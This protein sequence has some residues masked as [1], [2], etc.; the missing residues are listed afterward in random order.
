M[1]F[2][3]QPAIVIIVALILSSCVSIGKFPTA[4]PMDDNQTTRVKNTV[5]LGE[6]TVY[7]NVPLDHY[8]IDGVDAYCLNMF[9]VDLSLYRCFALE[10]GRLTKGLA[11]T[12]FKWKVLLA[13]IDITR[14]KSI[15]EMI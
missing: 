11:P 2:G 7:K 14:G 1:S 6:Q 13:P 12:T 10:G 9:S 4:I 3:K 15:K 8:S 5:E